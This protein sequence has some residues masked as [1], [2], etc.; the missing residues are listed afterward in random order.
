MITEI[1]A[2]HQELDNRRHFTK[3]GAPIE[4]ARNLVAD[5]TAPARPVDLTTIS[6]S[7]AKS[8]SAA[9]QADLFEVG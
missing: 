2:S 1:R 7:T 6:E 3:E 5:W 9:S 8:M 4:T